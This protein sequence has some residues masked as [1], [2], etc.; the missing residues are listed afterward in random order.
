MTT[1]KILQKVDFFQKTMY[2]NN[3]LIEQARF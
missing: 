1:F 2:L 3:Q